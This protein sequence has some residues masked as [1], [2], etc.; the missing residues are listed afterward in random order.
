MHRD[1]K[2]ANVLLNDDMNI[3]NC[4]VGL[5]GSVVDLETTS[6]KILK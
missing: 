5:S 1:L 6:K 4:D 3:K 2:P